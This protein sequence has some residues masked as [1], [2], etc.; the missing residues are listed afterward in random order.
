MQSQ[1]FARSC[2]FDPCASV[3]RQRDSPARALDLGTK[4]KLEFA[5]S[6]IAA[7]C[8]INGWELATFDETLGSFPTSPVGSLDNGKHRAKSRLD[9]LFADD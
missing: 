1:C 2:A 4:P 3:R 9:S 8:E 5:D 6:V 7:R